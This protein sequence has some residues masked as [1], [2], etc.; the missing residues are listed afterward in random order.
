MKEHYEIIYDP[1][2]NIRAIGCKYCDYFITR[3]DVKATKS[4]HRWPAMS[5]AI[6]RHLRDK[7]SINLYRR[8]E[9]V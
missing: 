4:G 9:K 7:H 3:S 6:K 1:Y 8:K 2:D 5:H